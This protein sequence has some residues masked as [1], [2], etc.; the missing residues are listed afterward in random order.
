V[1]WVLAEVAAGMRPGSLS[2][3]RPASP[4]FKLAIKNGRL[5]AVRLPQ[6]PD[7]RCPLPYRARA[8]TKHWP[9]RFRIVF[10]NTQLRSF[11]AAYG[12]ETDAV[13]AR[14]F[15]ITRAEVRR[16]SER[17]CLSKDKRF[18]HARGEGVKMPRWGDDE[19][20]WLEDHYADT[21]NL[22]IARQL[23]RS[24]KSVGSKASQRGLRKSD[25]RLVQM[26]RENKARQSRRR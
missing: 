24:V 9:G 19:L 3:S 8:C 25:T 5:V 11:K 21:P 16:L 18:M 26:G 6:R 22:E 17:Y 10:N 7:P 15:R 20:S 12:S 13:L 23:G 1:L 2:K 14:R 4:A